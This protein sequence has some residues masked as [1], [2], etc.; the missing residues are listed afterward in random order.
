[1]P[2]P[3]RFWRGIDA[4]LADKWSIESRPFLFPLPGDRLHLAEPVPLLLLRKVR[5]RVH[6]EAN[7]SG[8]QLQ[9]RRLG[10]M[11]FGQATDLESSSIPKVLMEVHRPRH[12][13]HA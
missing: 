10:R 2:D 1:M 3:L 12:L 5:L 9:L 6:C 8:V 11:E 13:L 4:G 7:H